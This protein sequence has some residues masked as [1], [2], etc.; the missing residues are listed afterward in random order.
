[1]SVAYFDVQVSCSASLLSGT[2]Q[3]EGKLVPGEQACK[4]M[5]LMNGV[6]KNKKIHMS[7]DGEVPW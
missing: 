4:Y 6:A 5:H 1:M 7:Q 2:K 3:S